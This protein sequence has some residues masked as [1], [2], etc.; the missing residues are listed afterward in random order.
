LTHGAF[1]P[2][3]FGTGSSRWSSRRFGDVSNSK[4]NRHASMPK[5]VLALTTLCLGFEKPCYHKGFVPSTPTSRNRSERRDRIAVRRPPRCQRRSRL[6]RKG[7]KCL[8]FSHFEK[9]SSFMICI[10]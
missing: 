6:Q 8:H 9:R 7:R 5:T 4:S 2:R 10:Q 1:F 3:R